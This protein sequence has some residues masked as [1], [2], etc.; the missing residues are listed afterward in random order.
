MNCTVVETASSW[1]RVEGLQK[2]QSHC[3]RAK[4]PNRDFQSSYSK[5]MSSL[6]RSHSQGTHCRTLQ[7]YDL[8]RDHFLLDCPCQTAAD[9]GL[10]VKEETLDFLASVCTCVSVPAK[11]CESYT[12]SWVQGLIL[13]ALKTD[14]TCDVRKIFPLVCQRHFERHQRNAFFSS[15]WP[16]PSCP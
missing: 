13:G 12:G 10:E 3:S 1:R 4:G 14:A 5:M 11:W 8:E 16:E 2:P 6:S 7:T 9:F 15:Q